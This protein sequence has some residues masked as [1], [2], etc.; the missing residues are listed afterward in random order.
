MTPKSPSTALNDISNIY[1]PTLQNSQPQTSKWKRVA[2]TDACRGDNLEILTGHKWFS[3]FDSNC[4]KLPKKKKIL[5]SQDDKENSM[6]LAEAG[7]QPCQELWVSYV[8]IV[9]GLGTD[10]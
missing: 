1:E 2:H 4:S 5:V 3:K 6:V 8:G 7:S 10:R 9:V